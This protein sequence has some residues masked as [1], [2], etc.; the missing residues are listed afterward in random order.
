MDK[1]KEEFPE[2]QTF[3]N[4]VSAIEDA[5]LILI[6][7]KPWKVETV[8]YE[9]KD[10]INPDTQ[11]IGSM[12]GGMNADEVSEYFRRSD[13]R[14][15]PVYYIIPNTAATISESMTFITGARTSH[16]QD[17]MVKKLFDDL[18]QT[19][20]VEPRMMNAGMAIASCGIAF[21]MRYIRANIE[22]GIELGLYAADA[23]KAII[24]T[25]RGA[26]N[27]LETSGTHPE[28][29][30]DKVTTPGGI[31]IRGLNAME[32]AGFSAAIIEGLRKSGTIN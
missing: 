30:I 1:L 15:S 16:E 17:Q 22:G 23:K 6:A 27:L 31:T 13:G 3:Q 11:I 26:A 12:V 8:A 4:N 19:L 20:L 10:I 9:I 28:E 2:L 24:Q 32:K 5:D 18:G 7:V 14:V 29:E 21:A 25:L